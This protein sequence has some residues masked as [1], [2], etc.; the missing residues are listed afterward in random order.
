[1]LR[2]NIPKE[3][4][5]IRKHNEWELQ[6]RVS[7]TFEKSKGFN[8]FKQKRDLL[9][10]ISHVKIEGGGGWEGCECKIVL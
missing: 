1:M 8:H 6:K 4:L 10:V 7:K 9:C 5:R 3:K 2:M